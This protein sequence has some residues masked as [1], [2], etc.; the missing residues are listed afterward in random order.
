M[1][2][3]I[4]I[5]INEFTKEYLNPALQKISSENKCCSLVGDFNIDLIKTDTRPEINIFY[6]TLMSNFFAPYIHQPTRPES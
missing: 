3:S 5:P 2:P 6:S 4:V 1:H